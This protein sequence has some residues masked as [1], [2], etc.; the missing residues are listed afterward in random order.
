MSPARIAGF[1]VRVTVAPLIDTPSTDWLSLPVTFTGKLPVTGTE[2]VSR[3]SSKV[4]VRDVPSTWAD[5]GS[6]LTPST[7]W[8]PSSVRAAWVRAAFMLSETAVMLPLFRVSLFAEMA[9]P[10]VSASSSPT[11]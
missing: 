2:S 8:P 1:S 11:L 6:G 3:F 10:L 4:M 7:L 9:M 5:D